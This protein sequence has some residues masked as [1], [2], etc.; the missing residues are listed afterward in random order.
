MT[1]PFFSPLASVPKT[2]EAVANLDVQIQARAT[3]LASAVARRAL[4]EYYAA[5]L[6][7]PRLRSGAISAAD[8]M[9]PEPATPELALKTISL[10]LEGAQVYLQGQMAARDAQRHTT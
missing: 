10:M 1:Q 9:P 2:D 8:W 4:A 7:D 3:E 5:M 6:R